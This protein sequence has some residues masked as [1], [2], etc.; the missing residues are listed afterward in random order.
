MAGTAGAILDGT[1]LFGTAAG[2]ACSMGEKMVPMATVSDVGAGV[3]IRVMFGA[4][5]GVAADRVFV[6]SV[7]GAQSIG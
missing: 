5:V 3:Y 2:Q 6:F 7:L 4:F 1:L